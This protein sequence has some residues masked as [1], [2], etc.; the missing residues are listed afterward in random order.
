MRVAMD[1]QIFAIQQY[2]GISR[3]FF[4]LAKQFT[5]S[6]G[7]GVELNP[8]DAPIVNR[9]VLEN[10]QLAV[11]LEASS[12]KSNFTALAH[13]FSRRTNAHDADIVHNTFYLPNGLAGAKTAKKVVTIYDM[14]P[15]LLPKTRR[16]LDLLTMKRHYV[17][18]ADH[19][20]CISAAT[21]GDLVRLYPEITAP[22]TVVHLGVDPLF[23]PGIP[24]WKDLPDNY[25]LFVGNRG[26]YKDAE[27]LLRAFTQFRR[28]YPDVTLLFV[29]GGLFTSQENRLIASLGI[30][31]QTLQRSLPDKEMSSAYGNAFFTVFPSRF[32]GFGL[33]VLE[34]MACGTATLLADATSLPEVGGDAALYFSSGDVAELAE[35]MLE[36]AGDTPLREEKGMAGILQASKFSWER[37]A[38]ETADVYAATLSQ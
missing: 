17:R 36:L 8:L 29:G 20:I 2:G 28:Q 33:P 4:E 12:A 7:L 22:I 18:Q 27:V 34:S 35:R 26:Q 38:Q 9:Y 21:R 3:L 31:S 37:C 10:P 14:I 13:Y 1:E 15:E 32:E 23:A 24:R 25:V 5:T 16:R 19:I 11:A 30:S 6:P